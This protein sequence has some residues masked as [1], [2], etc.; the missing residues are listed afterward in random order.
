M[1]GMWRPCGVQFPSLLTVNAPLRPQLNRGALEPPIPGR[2]LG[3]SQ[4]GRSGR[5]GRCRVFQPLVDHL[6]D[7][8]EVARH[9][10]G[11]ELV[12]LESVFDRL[13]GLTCVLYINL[14]S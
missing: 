6:V 8:T 14:R 4:L 12:T 5:F 10:R 11:E 7:D 9:L 1:G 2:D 3:T 13:I